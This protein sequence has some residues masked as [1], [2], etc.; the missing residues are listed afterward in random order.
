MTFLDQFSPTCNF[1]VVKN[2]FLNK[3]KLKISDPTP[4]P[5]IGRPYDI[6]LIKKQESAYT[7][8]V[9][10]L[11][12]HFA[13]VLKPQ[14]IGREHLPQE[15][16]IIYVANHLE[17]FD[18]L[19]IIFATEGKFLHYLA[20]SNFYAEYTG[21]RFQRIGCVFVDRSDPQD[22]FRATKSLL[23]ILKQGGNVLIFPEGHR[24]KT[25]NLLGEMKIGIGKL[26]KIAKVPIV[27]LFNCHTPLGNSLSGLCASIIRMHK[28]SKRLFVIGAYCRSFNST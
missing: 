18:F 5:Y 20:A 22:A 13:E 6:E 4:R 2:L 19:P 23:Q 10:M 11:K 17:W 21:R 16:G 27:L 8:F 25:W 1:S 28:K 3:I 12:N 26:A 14:V 15:N 7:D 9:T 24:N